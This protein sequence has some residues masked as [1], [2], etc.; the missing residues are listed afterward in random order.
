MFDSNHFKPGRPLR[1]FAFILVLLLCNFSEADDLSQT[2][3]QR[4]ELQ[5][6]E[7]D[8]IQAQLRLEQ[9]K[10]DQLDEL[11]NKGF[12][13]WLEVRRHQ[14]VVDS[15]AVRLKSAVEFQSFLSDVQVEQQSAIDSHTPVFSKRHGS[16]VKVFLPGS[17]R[18]IGWIE[19]QSSIKSTD[20]R[21]HEIELDSVR[22]RLAKAQKRFDETKK[23]QSIPANWIEKASLDLSV[24]KKEFEYVKALKHFPIPSNIAE[25]SQT[26]LIDGI[27]NF[28]SANDCVELRR[29]T[30]KVAKAEATAMGQIECAKIMLARQQQ[31]VDAIARLHSEGYASANELQSVSEQVSR[32]Q[33]DL[34]M[35]IEMQNT[36]ANASAKFDDPD[37]SP[38]EVAYPS[39]SA[40]PII[41]SHD[42][43]FAL[44]LIDLRR[45]SYL[46]SSLAQIA[47]LKSGM[48]QDVA[49]RLKLAAKRGTPD[50]DFG[51]V[52]N[53]GQR[54]E[55]QAYE[56]EIELADASAVAADEKRRTYIHEECRFIQQAIAQYDAARNQMVSSNTSFF[57]ALGFLNWFHPTGAVFSSG[58]SHWV[59]RYSY[60]ESDRFNALDQDSCL[61]YWQSS[62]NFIGSP[63]LPDSVN[64]VHLQP[65][66]SMWL[67]SQS[68]RCYSSASGLQVDPDWMKYL[69]C[70]V[71]RNDDSVV[72]YP[73]PS[74]VD[75]LKNGNHYGRYGYR[76]YGIYSAYPNGILRSELRSRA[77]VGQL[78]WY[79]PGSPSNLRPNDFR[80]RD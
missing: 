72:P 77:P 7:N 68:G 76:S 30:S 23:L 59:P 51:S 33:L 46:E 50:S 52:L 49:L 25:A 74:I 18:V 6:A 9:W 57:S 69:R 45:E 12:A 21:A 56:T 27:K 11:Y 53:E 1:I 67:S 28:V 32:I 61:L 10:H 35:L 41:V 78:P 31:R 60:L 47:R 73:L 63:Y 62:V 22:E 15:I 44:H 16:P 54:N 26:H 34:N 43:E 65:M 58:A 8:L 29:A 13:S 55:I 79:L 71:E 37:D 80:F 20:V 48:L 5:S 64:R 24:A 17:I 38:S 36:L 14:L 19:G 42:R 3:Q 39:V 66:Q 75:D 4:L 2:L 70:N 40:W